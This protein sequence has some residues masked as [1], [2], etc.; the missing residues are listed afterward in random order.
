MVFAQSARALPGHLARWLVRAFVSRRLTRAVLNNYYN[1]LTPSRKARFHRRYY[2]VF[3]DS[4]HRLAGGEWTVRFLGNILRLPLRPEHSWLDWATAVSIVGH[5]LEVKQTYEFFLR[6]RAPPQAF[7]DVG[8]NY[9]THSILLA[10]QGVDAIAFEPNPNCR[11]YARTVC[12][13]NHLTVRW[14]PV[15]LGDRDGEVELVYPVGETWLG[16]VVHDVSS[17]LLSSHADVAVKSVDLRRLDQYVEGLGDKR[18]LM[19]IDVEGSELLVLRGAAALLIRLKPA[20][21]FES[22][23]PG[24]RTDLLS[25]LAAHRYLLFKLPF[26]GLATGVLLDDAQFCSSPDTNFLALHEEAAHSY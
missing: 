19:K 23:D 14:E 21:V 8:A 12:A 16:S 6:S 17:G 7:L 20:I 2:Q 11:E 10:S 9:G 24:T 5:D 4:R 22:N 25:L 15:A 1:G 13:L 3:L 18:L 26:A